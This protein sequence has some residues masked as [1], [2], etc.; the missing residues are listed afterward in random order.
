MLAGLGAGVYRDVSDALGDAHIR[1]PRS[2]RISG[3]KAAYD[4]AFGRY[5]QVASSAVVR[6]APQEVD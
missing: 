5:R 4:D 3:T 6:A 2:T 1:V